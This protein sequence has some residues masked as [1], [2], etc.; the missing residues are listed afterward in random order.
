MGVTKRLLAELEERGWESVDRSVCAECLTDEVLQVEVRAQSGANE[1]NFCDRGLPAA[2]IDVVLALISDGIHAEYEDPIGIM[3]WDSEEGGYVGA[4]TCEIEDI[5]WSHEVSDDS[6]LIRTLSGAFRSQQRCQRNPYAPSPEQALLWGWEHF[7]EHVITRRRF[8]FLLET[9]AVTES[10]GAGEHGPE[11]M[12]EHIRTAITH[13]GLATVLP[14]GTKLHR[15]RVHDA[16][17]RPTLATELGTSPIEY[18]RANRMT[19]EGIPAFYGASTAAGAEAEVGYASTGLITLGTFETSQDLPIIDLT[20]V[21]PP[22]SLFDGS[23]RHLRASF[24]FLRAFIDDVSRPIK[25]GDEHR[26]YIP[27][28]IITEYLRYE[29]SHP[30]GQVMGIR[31]CSAKDTSVVNTALFIEN[32]SCVEQAHGWNTGPGPTLGLVP[33]SVTPK[34]LPVPTATIAA[35]G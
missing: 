19:P 7:R 33:E 9:P 5:L 20:D 29:Y 21:G 30:A 34:A 26:Q 31:W 24:M 11:T 18:A 13:G 27:T 3:G 12:P 35:A 22:P 1:C 23:R 15:A 10:L 25:D 2:S 8:T 17:I 6:V 4:G 32:S 16:T 14:A 28:Q